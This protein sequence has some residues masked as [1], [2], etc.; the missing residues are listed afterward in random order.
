MFTPAE[1]VLEVAGFGQALPAEQATARRNISKED[2][3]KRSES[4]TKSI[5]NR[6]LAAASTNNQTC[7][8]GEVK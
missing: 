3:N 5:E 1:H 2:I 4:S 8:G 6:L 7:G